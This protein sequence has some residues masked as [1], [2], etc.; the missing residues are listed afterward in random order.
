[1]ALNGYLPL[2]FTFPL[3]ITFLCDLPLVLSPTNCYMTSISYLSSRCRHLREITMQ[4][5][6]NWTLSCN[7]KYMH[8]YF[9]ILGRNLCVV[10]HD[11]LWS[12]TE[13]VQ[14]KNLKEYL[15]ILDTTGSSTHQEWYV[16]F[17]WHNVEKQCDN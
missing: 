10:W 5:A 9:R 8:F 4:T 3:T 14:K 1:M 12:R 13:M 11:F 16:T 2:T 6:S 17:L 15:N 7:L